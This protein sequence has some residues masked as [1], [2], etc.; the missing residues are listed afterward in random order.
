MVFSTN[1][2]A[3]IN[4]IVTITLILK[5]RLYPKKFLQCLHY[6]TLEV[7]RRA[8]AFTIEKFCELALTPH[9]LSCW[10]YTVLHCTNSGSVFCSFPSL[11]ETRTSCCYCCCSSQLF[12]LRLFANSIPIIC[13]LALDRFYSASEWVNTQ[14]N[15]LSVAHCILTMISLKQNG[16]IENEVFMSI[17]LVLICFEEYWKK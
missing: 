9:S 11:L 1:I 8:L 2:L 6:K 16:Q 12:P 14:W 10:R 17:I 7:M 13:L 15:K 3:N 5:V 4:N